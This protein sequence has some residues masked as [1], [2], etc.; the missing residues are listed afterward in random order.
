MTRLRVLVIDD[1]VA[2]RLLCRINLEAD[3][4]SVIEA[5]DGAAGLAAAL[6]EIPDIILLDVMMPGDDGVTVAERMVAEESLRDVPIIFL[7]A[8]VDLEDVERVRRVG[9][10]GTITKPFNPIE[11]GRRVRE[12]VE[13]RERRRL[14]ACTSPPPN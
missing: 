11:L 5:P 13:E 8:R 9:A 1:E 3:G 7:T 12:V 10:A 4:I 14:D 2:I 6:R